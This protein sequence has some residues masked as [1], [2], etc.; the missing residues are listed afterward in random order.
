MQAIDCTSLVVGTWKF[1]NYHFLTA[2][3]SKLPIC[4]LDY[5]I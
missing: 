1:V 4:L 3:L 5:H 2:V